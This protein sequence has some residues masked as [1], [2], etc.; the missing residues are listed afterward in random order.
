MTPIG[1]TDEFMKNLGA[2]PSGPAPALPPNFEFQ[3]PPLVKQIIMPKDII[4]APGK[5]RLAFDLDNTL[6]RYPRIL[7]VIMHEMKNAGHTCIVL[8]AAP[9]GET[10]QH[11]EAMLKEVGI[12]PGSYTAIALVLEDGGISKA[13][14]CKDNQIDILIDDLQGNLDFCKRDSPM[15]CRL[16]VQ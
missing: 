1:A 8:T 2:L 11:R 13:R 5:L 9:A 15:T 14:F 12:S 10:V 6:N 16:K 3:D 4:N 7:G